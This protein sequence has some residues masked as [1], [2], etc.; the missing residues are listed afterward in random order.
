MLRDQ[1]N[2]FLDDVT[3][4]DVQNA[5]QVPV[6]SVK[7][8]GDDLVGEITGLG[9]LCGKTDRFRPYEPAD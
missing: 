2:V 5:L 4:T 9:N 6:V 3:V 7:S 8:S 1:E